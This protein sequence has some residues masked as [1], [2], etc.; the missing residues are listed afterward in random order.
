MKRINLSVPDDM[1]DDI[2]AQKPRHKTLSGFCLDIIADR[3]DGVAN[4]SA[5]HVGA[6]RTESSKAFK[7][8]GSMAVS[9][10]DSVQEKDSNPSLGDSFGSVGGMGGGPL[11]EHNSGVREIEQSWT[12]REYKTHLP[13]I[14]RTKTTWDVREDL[15]QHEASMRQYWEQK[16]GKKTLQAWTLFQTE[17][18]KLLAIGGHEQVSEHIDDLI[19]KSKK[20]AV[21]LPL[22][23]HEDLIFEFWRIK[24]GSKSDTAWKMLMNEL[25]KILAKYS[26]DKVH[27][28]LL[29]AINGKWKGITMTNLTRFENTGNKQVQEPPT[30]HPASRVFTAD[31]GFL[32]WEVG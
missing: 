11:L 29:L 7:A 21:P 23:E 25:G 12:P 18:A 32:D 15:L 8:V 19:S 6:G 4:L 17:L 16:A 24:G 1:Y 28:Q 31:K 3:V 13:K 26:H 22:Q 5:Y 30:R 20:R 2:V 9:A 27:E 10:V 14:S